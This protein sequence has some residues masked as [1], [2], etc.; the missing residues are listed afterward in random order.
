MIISLA[1]FG[2]NPALL[3]S[4]FFAKSVDGDVILLLPWILE[5]G[6]ITEPLPLILLFRRS[7]SVATHCRCLID[8]PSMLFI[9]RLKC[10]LSDRE[11][12]RNSRSPSET[13]SEWLR[14]LLCK[15]WLWLSRCLD[16][17]WNYRI[18]RQSS[19]RSNICRV[20]RRWLFRYSHGSIPAR[21]RSP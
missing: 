19:D 16:N 11:F 14:H 20:G 8:T 1:G 9:E 2:W 3:P 21:P 6:S 17:L 13:D 7:T 18:T 12:S 15:V 10:H 5:Y 4:Y